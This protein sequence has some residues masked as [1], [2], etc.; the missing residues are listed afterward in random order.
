MNHLTAFN[1]ISCLFLILSLSDV[2]LQFINIW[3]QFKMSTITWF[4]WLLW[5]NSSIQLHIFKTVNTQVWTVALMVKVA[6]CLQ[7][8]LTKPKHLKYKTK[9]NV[10]FK[11]HNLHPSV[12][13]LNNGHQNTTLG[14]SMHVIVAH[15]H[16]FHASANFSIQVGS[17]V[18]FCKVLDPKLETI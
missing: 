14:A 6:F 1:E 17:N 13:A 16:P 2:H 9:A 3:S 11:Q 4:T 12:W 18:L 5:S 10:A 15:Y 7:K 8:A